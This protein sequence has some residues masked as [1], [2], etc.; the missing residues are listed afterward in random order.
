MIRCTRCLYPTTRPDSHFDAD[1]VCSGCR[2]FEARKH[3]DWYARWE[4]F[5]V[6]VEEAKARKAPYDLVVPVS[7]G[8]D[9]T[10]QVIK[11]LELGAKVLAVGTGNIPLKDLAAHDPTYVVA[12]LTKITVEQALA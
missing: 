3:I 6:L 10:I 12:D 7:G 2:S 4:A 9:S 11:C 1:G 5:V 8:K